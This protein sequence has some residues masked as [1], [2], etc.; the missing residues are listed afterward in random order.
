[1]N[2]HLLTRS[3]LNGSILSTFPWKHS[4]PTWLLWPHVWDHRICRRYYMPQNYSTFFFF[5]VLVSLCIFVC[6]CLVLRNHRIL[7]KNGMWGIFYSKI[8]I[9]P[10]RNLKNGRS[11]KTCH[12]YPASMKK[13]WEQS[14]SYMADLSFI[15]YIQ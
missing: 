4:Y 11:Y 5:L 13:I 12:C 7:N 10:M 2:T 6:V 8:L 15:P 9:L 3:W 14:K 1:M